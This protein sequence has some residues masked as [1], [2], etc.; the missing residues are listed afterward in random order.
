MIEKCYFGCRLI[1]RVDE[2]TIAFFV[3]YARAKDIKEWSGIRRVTESDDG[4][5]RVLRPPRRKAI[6]RFLKSN[7][8]NTIPSNILLAFNPETADFTSLSSV[9]SKCIPQIDLFNNC[10]Q[11]LDWGKLTFQ[12]EANTAE[13]SK[14]A[15]IVDGQHRLYGVSDFEDENLPLLVVSLIDAP[16][17]EQ[18]F[19][20]VVINNKAVRVP[21]DNVRAIIAQIDEEE[22]Q[23][24]LL[25]AGVS[26]GEK[27]PILRDINDLP[28]SPFQHLLNWPYNKVGAQLVPL[29]AIEQSLRYLQILF[30]SL[31]DDEDSL[32]EIFCAMWRA[33]KSNYP[34]IWGK[35]NT[36]MKKVNINALNEF[37]GDRLKFAWEM[38]LID[39]FD[40]AAVEQQVSNIVRL[41]PEEFWKEEWAVRIQDNANVRNLIK[42]DLATLANNSKLR[43]SWREDLKLPVA[44]NSSDDS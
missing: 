40:S 43:K 4:I 34:T 16:I 28:S 30:P 24:R 21:T 41:L 25:K 13:Q 9:V 36:F 20:F 32:I 17:Q 11:Q 35:E 33:V 7:S 39:V 38:N 42:A 15:L 12:F 26:Y 22:L 31:E 8:V 2:E 14:P 44:A 27:S 5:Q 29:T 19:Q 37:V 18:A 10:Q 1:Q 3:F 6:T 23:S